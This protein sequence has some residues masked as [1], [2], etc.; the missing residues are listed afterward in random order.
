MEGNEV[1]VGFE[2]VVNNQFHQRA[3]HCTV[4][5][6]THNSIYWLVAEYPVS[7]LRL[8]VH[9]FKYDNM[10]SKVAFKDWFNF[11]GAKVALPREPDWEI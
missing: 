10:I 3:E 8:S 4:C 11:N 9:G 2:F 6:I 5:N 7:P 1:Y